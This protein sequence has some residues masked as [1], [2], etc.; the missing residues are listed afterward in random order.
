MT[1]SSIVNVLFQGFPCVGVT[2]FVLSDFAGGI[3]VSEAQ[4]FVSVIAPVFIAICQAM[5][6]VV[7]TRRKPIGLL[8]GVVGTYIGLLLGFV[9]SAVISNRLDSRLGIS[10]FMGYSIFLMLYLG[11]AILFGWFFNVVSV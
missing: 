3:R 5:L 8:A 11:A 7:V 9:M 10:P 6:V 2:I 4:W 1:I